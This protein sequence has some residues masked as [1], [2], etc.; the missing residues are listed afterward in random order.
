MSIIVEWQYVGRLNSMRFLCLAVATLIIFATVQN[1]IS[2]PVLTIF[3]NFSTVPLTA[4]ML[5]YISEYYPTSIR[6]SALAYFNNMSALFGTFFPYLGGYTT[7]LFGQF[8]WLFPS[9][10]A[11]FY[12]LV[13]VS[14]SL[15]H[16]TLM[17]NL[18][19]Q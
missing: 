12:L 19:D 13:L 5:S 15:Q 2:V 1:D 14:F 8:P 7:D 4:L 18:M 11:V 9:I 16:E 17:V 10:W 6:G 3:V